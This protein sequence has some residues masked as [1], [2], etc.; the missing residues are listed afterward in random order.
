LERWGLIG[1]FGFVGIPGQGKAPKVYYLR[2]KG[3][4]ILCS[5]ARVFAD[6]IEPFSD[7]QAAWT[8]YMYH[9]LRIIDCLISAEV[10]A[11]CAFGNG[12]SFCGI[13]HEKT[14]GRASQG[15]NGFC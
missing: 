14:P 5:E 7:V 8:P 13:P 15:N 9:R 3:Y 1:W 4:D 12:K 2:R 6:Q 11:P 10:A